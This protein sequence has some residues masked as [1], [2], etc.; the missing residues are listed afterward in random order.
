M[1]GRKGARRP[2]T[3]SLAP[4]GT[5]PRMNG[6]QADCELQRLGRLRWWPPRGKGSRRR[7][8][9]G[10]D[11]PCGGGRGGAACWG[12]GLG[13]R[14]LPRSGHAPGPRGGPGVRRL[15][16]QCRLPGAPGPVSDRRGAGRGAA[17]G[18]PA[19][20]EGDAGVRRP[21]RPR[22]IE[23]CRGFPGP[24]PR[25]PGGPGA[26][27]SSTQ[28]SCGSCLHRV[29]AASG[30]EQRM[31]YSPRTRFHSGGRQGICAVGLEMDLTQAYL[32][33]TA[34]DGFSVQCGA[35]PLDRDRNS[36]FRR[37]SP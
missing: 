10:G 8:R 3:C 36:A 5:P 31:W 7:R 34:W 1:A 37:H 19:S 35:W 6:A 15:L 24:G 23:A 20:P 26:R 11:A 4:A 9:P 28:R 32:P 30:L 13:G 27:G 22:R 33:P 17:A 14:L 25:R 29:P 2:G 21:R 16:Q 12:G 18:D